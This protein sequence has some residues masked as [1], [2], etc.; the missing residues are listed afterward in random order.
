MSK[1]LLDAKSNLM[2]KELETKIGFE[3]RVATDDWVENDKERRLVQDLTE[4]AKALLVLLNR[5]LPFLKK[6]RR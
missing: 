1:D 5:E 3:P 4:I 2:Q 6:R